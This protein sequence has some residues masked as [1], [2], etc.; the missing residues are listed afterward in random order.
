M[1]VGWHKQRDELL[2]DYH[3]AADKTGSFDVDGSTNYRR[4]NLPDE[5]RIFE[6]CGTQC[7]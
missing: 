1:P 2:L 6:H 5:N 4:R 3:H 7:A